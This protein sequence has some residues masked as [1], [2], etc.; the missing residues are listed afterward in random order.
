MAIQVIYS[1][2]MLTP[3]I[4]CLRYVKFWHLCFKQED[5]L[6]EWMTKGQAMALRINI[7]HYNGFIF[8]QQLPFF[9]E[10]TGPPHLALVDFVA[11]RLADEIELDFEIF[12]ILYRLNYLDFYFVDISAM[13][14]IVLEVHF[15]LLF[16]NK[17]YFRVCFVICKIWLHLFSL[18]LGTSIPNDI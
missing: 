3:S 12:K 13:L 2:Y 5:Q 8:R 1:H 18:L 11:G 9:W 17:A 15:S 16:S 7:L 6:I 10:K 14:L 4:E